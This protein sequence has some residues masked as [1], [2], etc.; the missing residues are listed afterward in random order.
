MLQKHTALKCQIIYCLIV[1]DMLKQA[2]LSSFDQFCIKEGLNMLYY[3]LLEK[4]F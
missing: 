2:Q 3:G 4:Q 1:G